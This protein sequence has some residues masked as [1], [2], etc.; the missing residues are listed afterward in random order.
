MKRFIA[1]GL[2]V[3]IA[4]VVAA[5]PVTRLAKPDVEYAPEL[6][7]IVGIHELSDGRVV[8]LD[9]KEKKI[10]LLDDRGGVTPIGR[11]GAGPGEYLRPTSL[12]ALAGDSTLIEDGGNRRFLVL[13]PGGKP[14]GTAP[15]VSMKPQEGVLYTVTPRGVDAKGRLYVL[16]PTGLSGDERMPILRY[17]RNS[18]KY[19]T[20]ASI[21]NDRFNVQRGQPTVRSN[22]ASFGFNAP[23]PWAV[24]DEWAAFA[25]GYIVVA[26]NQPY[27]VDWISPTGSTMTG[28]AIPITAIK[29]TSKEKDAWRAQQLENA[30]SLT[31]TDASGKTTTQKM[32]VPEPE[33]WPEVFPA[34]SGQGSVVASPRGTVWIQRLGPA[35]SAVAYDIVDRAGKVAE[36]VELPAG[37]R[38]IGFGPSSVYVIRT[39]DDGLQHL[40]RYSRR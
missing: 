12:V 13:G 31:T 21:R 26:H 15:L 25:D 16:M 22:G 4:P 32:P 35:G 11:D 23:M 17:D 33:Q 30:P 24:K 2:L 9:R 29:V 37:H 8:L 7:G 40:Q 1:L 28:P 10:L 19:D 34:F 3:S 5:Q 36:R 14:I 6:S 18:G 38:V 39:D 20:A 27:S